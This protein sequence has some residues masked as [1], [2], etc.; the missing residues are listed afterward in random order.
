MNALAISIGATAVGISAHAFLLRLRPTRGHLLHLPPLLL[1]ALAVGIL[2]APLPEGTPVVEDIAVA[3]ILTL[4]LGFSY[5][6]VI[7]GVVH[8]SPTLAL[9]N[10]IENFGEAGMPLTAFDQFVVEHP[11]LRSR[12]DSLVAAGELSVENGS[13][14]LTGKAVHLLTV[15][16]AYRRLRGGSAS[17]TG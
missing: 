10:A 5:A 13:L 9:V 3:L 12:L 4:S 2:F 14:R 15:G 8:D 7:V 17:E 16:D 6:L 1:S 11:F